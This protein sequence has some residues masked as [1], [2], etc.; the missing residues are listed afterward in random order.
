M[1][2]FLL[3]L[4]FLASQAGADIN[5][6]KEPKHFDFLRGKTFLFHVA[7]NGREYLKSFS[8]ES[9]VQITSTAAKLNCQ[10]G[11]GETWAAY[12]ESASATLKPSVGVFYFIDGTVDAV[13]FYSYV[14]TLRYDGIYIYG[15]YAQ[16]LPGGFSEYR[17]ARVRQAI[18]EKPAE[19]AESEK[20][21]ETPIT[22]YL[23]PPR[24]PFFNTVQN[25]FDIENALIGTNG[26]VY[27]VTLRRVPPLTGYY[28][29]LHSANPR[30]P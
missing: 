8:C 17:S 28:F 16:S 5:A 12:F 26:P 7:E 4:L 18:I 14:Y 10:G 11:I 9:V 22:M 6:T 20:Q 21:F 30:K 25:T 13:P 1:R 3:S 2:R 27:N 19:P 23:S 15:S 24:R 29:E